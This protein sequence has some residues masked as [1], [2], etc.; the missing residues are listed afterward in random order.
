[1]NYIVL[2]SREKAAAVAGG[3]KRNR[4]QQQHDCPKLEFVDACS[5]HF[6]SDAWR[7]VAI[8]F[9][10]GD[11]GEG[12]WAAPQNVPELSRR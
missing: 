8:Q 1:M 12:P 7:Q 4:T 6:Q 5:A 9:P 11:Y 10:P 3:D 2:T